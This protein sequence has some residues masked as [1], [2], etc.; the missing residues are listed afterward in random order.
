MDKDEHVLDITHGVIGRQN[1]KKSRFS[2]IGFQHI[3]WTHCFS[4]EQNDIFNGL[5]HLN[6][7]ALEH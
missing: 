2:S 6:F 5:Y 7:K 4:S 3:N 1:A